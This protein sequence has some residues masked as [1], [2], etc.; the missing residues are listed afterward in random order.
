M[1]KHK[2][3]T[4]IELVVVVMILGILAAVAAPKLLNTSASAAENGLRESLGVMRDAIE[5]FAAEHGGQ[6]PGNPAGTAAAFTT[7][8]TPYL[9]GAAIPK[10]PCGNT[11]NTVSVV[12]GAV[13][14]TGTAGWMYSSGD[15]TFICNSNAATKVDP[16]VHYN[17]L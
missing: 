8:I 16:T 14:A 4:L 3:F 10:S 7:D 2:G 5:R 6:L 1:R 11:N 9:R 17:E 13:S 15:G 12:P